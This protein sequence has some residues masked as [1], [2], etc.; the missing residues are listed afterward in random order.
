[1]LANGKDNVS[2]QSLLEFGSMTFDTIDL[3]MY[4]D[5]GSGWSLIGDELEGPERRHIGTR[6]VS[7]NRMD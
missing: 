6:Y 1:M 7:P 2:C 4:N 3:S 5:A